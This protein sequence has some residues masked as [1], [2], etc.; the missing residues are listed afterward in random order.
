M[1]GLIDFITGATC[2]KSE[3][4]TLADF[5]ITNKPK[6]FSGRANIDFGCS[7]FQNL[8]VVASRIYA[9]KMPTR[10]ITYRCMKH[11]SDQS[12]SEHIECVSFHVSEIC[13]DNDDFHW[14]HYH[15]MSVIEHHA[16]LKTKFVKGKHLPYMN[17]DLSKAIK[18]RN[19]W[20]SR[21]F[22]NRRC[23]IVG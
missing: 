21:H 18:Q 17:S 6:C 12:F 22:R 3:G 10:Q 4:S 2:C 13:D 5:M 19:M 9:P 23:K 8:I 15:L 1:F 16:P 20:R 7:D 11:F 14:A